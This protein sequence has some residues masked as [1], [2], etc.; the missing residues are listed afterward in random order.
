MYEKIFAALKATKVNI[1]S[2]LLLL[3]I[4]AESSE[5][6]TAPEIGMLIRYLRINDA[7]AMNALIPVLSDLLAAHPMECKPV[8][9]SRQAA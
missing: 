8:K 6:L 5:Q 2:L 7:N 9:I 4:P 3:G 1:G